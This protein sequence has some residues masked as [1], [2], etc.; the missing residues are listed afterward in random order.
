MIVAAADEAQH[1]EILGKLLK[2]AW[3]RNVK[4]N[5]QKIQWKVSEVSY[6]RHVITV[7]GL[8]PDV[9]KVQAVTNLPTPTSKADRQRAL[10]VNFILRFAPNVSTIMPPL[11]N[12]LKDAR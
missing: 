10:R 4:F 7:K 5:Q 8:R 11:R 2:H 1:D 6:M 9:A 12:F 3:S